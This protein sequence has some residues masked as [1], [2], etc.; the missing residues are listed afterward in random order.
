MLETRSIK[1][2]YPFALAEGEG[3]GTAYEYVAK[4][5]VM[6]PLFERV[7]AGSRVLIAGLPEKYGTSLDFVLAG[8]DAGAKIV[9]VV[10]ARRRSIG[11]GRRSTNPCAAGACVIHR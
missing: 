5:R 1:A 7:S 11:R 9:A 3:V 6:K 2:L 4:R 10:S 8:V